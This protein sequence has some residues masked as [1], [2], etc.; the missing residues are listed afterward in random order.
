[1]QENDDMI[2]TLLEHPRNVPHF[3]PL[4]REEVHARLW[5]EKT[6]EDQQQEVGPPVVSEE[7]PS[8]GN[9]VCP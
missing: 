7:R 8:P 4:T 5:S 2:A 6:S 3:T 9:E 1:M